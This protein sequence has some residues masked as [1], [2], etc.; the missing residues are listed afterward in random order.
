MTEEQ[1]E[2]VR[3]SGA[4]QWPDAVVIHDMILKYKPLDVLELG[5]F[6][7]ASTL[8]ILDALHGT[9]FTLTSVDK[10]APG[11][12]IGPGTPRTRN[13][14]LPDDVPVHIVTGD[15]LEYL[16][17][18][19]DEC[20]DM[21]FEDTNHE[22]EYTSYLI[23]AIMR[24]LKPDGFALF[25]DLQLESMRQAFKAVRIDHKLILFPDTWMGMLL[26]SNEEE[27]HNG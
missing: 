1:F 13:A 25:H 20:L 21:V 7:G 19:P 16:K 9:N 23:P 17:G 14:H 24:V 26:K 2:A 4:I 22:T 15:A 10:V 18:L 3:F 6:M 8:V 12:V 5:A 11:K 27:N